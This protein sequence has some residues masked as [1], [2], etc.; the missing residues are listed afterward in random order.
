MS[1]QCEP[2]YSLLLSG[3]TARLLKK[4]E[5]EAK[6]CSGIKLFLF[7]AESQAK[8]FSRL[9]QKYGREFINV[10]CS[11]T[12]ARNGLSLSI[13]DGR[14]NTEESLLLEELSENFPGFNLDQYR[15]EHAAGSE[16]VL[17][18]ASAGTGKTTVMIDRITYLFATDEDLLPKDIGVIT[19]TNKATSSMLGK[20]QSRL[21][22][23]WSVTGRFRWYVLLEQLGQMQ[24][25]TLDSFFYGL[26]RSEGALLGYGR[27]A[28]ITSLVR[29]KQLI[30]RDILDDLYIRKPTLKPLTDNVLSL[31]ASEKLLLGIW[32]ELRSRGFFQKDIETADFGHGS[33]KDKDPDRYRKSER[34]CEIISEAIPEAERRY[35]K[36][37]QEL[38]AYALDDIRAELDALMQK[39][40]AL[41]VSPF[42]HLFVDEFQDTDSSQ[43]RILGWL[44][45]KMHFKLFVVGDVKQSIYRFRGAEESAFEELLMLLEKD[46]LREE[47]EILQFI[48]RK[49][50][51]TVPGIVE[52][53]NSIFRGW[54]NS[55]KRLL[56]WDSDAESAR[57][58]EGALRIYRSGCMPWENKEY[59]NEIG[60]EIHSLF[61]EHGQVCVLVRT[62]REVDKVFE[63][64]R[65]RRLPCVARVSGGFY[66]TR[67]VRDLHALL[68]A[69]L[70]PED[71]RFLWNLLE[72]PY[73]SGSPDP[74]M[75]LQLNG[76]EGKICS[77]L[78]SLL[79]EDQ[80]NKVVNAMRSK[81]FFPWLEQ[82]IATLNPVGR[83]AAMLHA[84]N[85]GERQHELSVAFYRL[86]LNKLLSILFEKFAGDYSSLYTVFNFLDLNIQTNYVEDAVYPESEGEGKGGFVEIMTVHKAKG[87]EFDTVLLP[88]TNKDFL[89][90]LKK[91]ETLSVVA[92][93]EDG[94]LVVGWQYA[95]HHNDL[96]D[97]MIVEEERAVCRDEAR[98]L[99][100][101]LTRAERN[102]KVMMLGCER[103][104][105]TWASLLIGRGL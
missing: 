91:S 43:I 27:S 13:A 24:L 38:N 48:L 77:Y 63:Q 96:F 89:L 8:R 97:R 82:T 57:S 104:E 40:Q 88:F 4:E 44:R 73:T 28:R 67:P 34:L 51:R 87:L 90:N 80:W 14:C 20:L 66:Q 50:Y 92:N 61:I 83:Y 65:K 102:L 59:L 78:R 11:P 54:S 46:G 68:G 70:H 58:G 56:P 71:T 6:I 19:F 64:C 60:R 105:E 5:A 35:R 3:R 10:Y 37:K 2:K 93:V 72:S 33:G 39:N 21:R 29:E 52:R 16:V 1:R 79:K 98:L 22:K 76:E 69:I 53:L 99:Y 36:R 42:R 81:T 30:I 75:V 41:R 9:S 94:R 45:K 23:M 17:V 86:N 26:I 12:G 103:L 18:R 47:K 7:V 84:G 74:E 101:A 15:V 100:V 85:D 62:N 49:N 55:S 95:D 25:S 32:N 31:S